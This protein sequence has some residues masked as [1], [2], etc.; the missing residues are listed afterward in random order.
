MSLIMLTLCIVSWT[1]PQPTAAQQAPADVR[2]SGR[3]SDADSKV[4]LTGARVVLIAAEWPSPQRPPKAREGVTDEDGRFTFEGVEPGRF[5]I[6]AEQ[7]GFAHDPSDTLLI[8]VAAG[9]SI[10]EIE[11][12]LRKSAVIAGRILHARGEPLSGIQVAALRRVSDAGHRPVLESGPM[13]ATN[14][15]GEFRIDGLRAG[16]YVVVATPQPRRPFEE[17]VTASDVLTAATYYPGTADRDAAHVVT[18]R[19][20]QTLGRLDFPMVSLSVFRISGV[21]MDEQG[22]PLA[23][24]MVM[25][26]DLRSGA[27]T[28]AMGRT[29]QDGTF[30]IA[31]V[32]PGSYRLI[33]V[34]PETR[35]PVAGG[36]TIASAGGV[37]FGSPMKNPVEAQ[38]TSADVTGLKIVLPASR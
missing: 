17:T 3:V 38:V 16:E 6:S 19:S 32:V 20:G 8:D 36:V 25:L 24:V 4:P 12:A 9:R 21:V 34:T 31:R 18:V 30:L 37:V 22:R 35:G 2:I 7:P 29:N 33:A 5:R 10:Q 23:D 26:M 13:S 15:L 14:D 1:L 27:P 28:P 11:L